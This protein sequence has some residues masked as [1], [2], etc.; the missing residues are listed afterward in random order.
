MKKQLLRSLALIG[1]IACALTASAEKRYLQVTS[2]SQLQTG[3]QYVIGLVGINETQW[4]SVNPLCYTLSDDNT[5][6]NFVS[7]PALNFTDKMVWTATVNTAYT[8]AHP[9]TTNTNPVIDLGMGHKVLQLAQNS[10]ALCFT[11]AAPSVGVVSAASSNIE[12]VP[13]PTTIGN[14]ENDYVFQLHVNPSSTT[15]FQNICGISNTGVAGAF[16]SRNDNAGTWLVND[17]FNGKNPLGGLYYSSLHRVYLVIDSDNLSIAANALWKSFQEEEVVGRDEAY[18]AAVNALE[19][20]DVS[21]YSADTFEIQLKKAFKQAAFGLDADLVV[22]LTPSTCDFPKGTGAWNNTAIGINNQYVK[23]S[24]VSGAS[25]IKP[26]GT[27]LDCRAGQA[28]TSVYQFESYYP[29]Y[30][31]SGFM[32]TATSSAGET[33]TI[34]GEATVLSAEGTDLYGNNRFTVTGE[35]QELLIDNISVKLNATDARTDVSQSGWYKFINI[36]GIHNKYTGRYAVNVDDEYRQNATN[37]Y[38]LG[39]TDDVSTKPAATLIY[40]EVQGNNKYIKS[41]NGHYVNQNCTS[42]LNLPSPTAF[43]A[44]ENG[45]VNIGGYWNCYQPTTSINLIGQGSSGAGGRRWFV[46]AFDPTQEYDIWTVTMLNAPAATEI[47]QNVRVECTS[48]ANKGISKVFNNGT[49]F[50]TRGTNLTESNFVADDDY[51]DEVT[52]IVRVDNAAKTVT[53]EYVN[54]ESYLAH[55]KELVSNL[56]SLYD[57]K[58]AE[59]AITEHCAAIKQAAGEDNILT[60][61]EITAI[62]TAFTS[63]ETF[64]TNIANLNKTLNGKFVQFRNLQHNTLYLA[65]D[66]T[67]R[68][69]GV[70]DRTALNTIWQLVLADE[71]TGAMYLKNYA[72]N[73]M[74]QNVTANETNVPMSE[75]EGHPFLLEPYVINNNIVYGLKDTT[76][77]S[78]TH[79][80]HQVTN[81]GNRI[82]KW[83]YPVS[84]NASG[85]IAALADCEDAAVEVTA[86]VKNETDGRG[87][88]MTLSHADGLSLHSAYN[89][90]LHAIK[91]TYK[92]PASRADNDFTLAPT[93]M[94][95]NTDDNTVSFVLSPNGELLPDSDYDVEIPLA[96]VKVGTGKYS[97]PLTAS[98]HVAED[99]TVTGINEVKNAAANAPAAIFDLQGRRL[100]KPAKGINIINGRKVLVK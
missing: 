90:A 88:I 34:D 23:L 27:K 6:I 1:G 25:N 26:N 79:Y 91:V 68:A 62:N 37:Y 60:A 46:S 73:K 58:D 10:N 42:S 98:I 59:Q 35:N 97:K 89:E 32:L 63:S 38:S 71:A 50:I 8:C 30:E 20:P 2:E 19:V 47:G 84:S 92:E 12:F 82:V 61:E 94:Q 18:T 78:H 51:T 77:G 9:H 13:C 45:S 70:T 64:S 76:P 96:A 14:V 11:G 66:N 17:L 31:V 44:T 86:E 53:V 100:S 48:N 85:W 55:Y 69:A 81:T 72:D 57:A 22:T 3:G 28:K 40:I 16:T 67:P 5:Q 4:Q 83:N 74:I 80:L 52:P 54:K 15:H 33:I 43:I 36:R 24:V 49:F 87:W 41:A 7:K 93:L 95:H 29:Y 99:G 21:Q 65:D 56:Y 39:V 75:T